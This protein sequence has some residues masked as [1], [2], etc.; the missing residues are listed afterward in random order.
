MTN[1]KSRRDEL[2]KFYDEAHENSEPTSCYGFHFSRGFDAAISELKPEIEKL[3]KALGQVSGCFN[4]DGCRETAIEALT[5]F[6]EFMG[7]G[8]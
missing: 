1:L 8:E 5:N 4:C 3:V 6:K 7:D 2:I